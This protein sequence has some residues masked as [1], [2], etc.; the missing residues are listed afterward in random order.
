ML[1][2]QNFL[3]T[4]TL[5]DLSAEFALKIS[6]HPTLPLVILNYNQIESP[7][8]EPLTMECRGL[9]LE[10]G[11][12][13]IVARS[14]C[15]FFNF[16]ETETKFI[17]DQNVTAHEKVDGS[18]ILMYFYG[19]WHI[20]TRGSF[21]DG[22]LAFTGK[23]WKEWVLEAIPNKSEIEKLDPAFT[24]IMEFVSPYNKVVRTYPQPQMYLLS[25]IQ[26]NTGF[27]L[28]IDQSDVI[29]SA[30]GVF[31]PKRFSLKVPEEIKHFLTENS[32]SDPTFEG[33]VLVDSIGNRVKFKAET[34]VNLHHLVDNGNIFNPSRL[35]PLVLNG[36]RDEVVVYL[37]EVA[38][39]FDQVEE[40]LSR[41]FNQMI[42][43]WEKVK[44]IE[45]QKEFAIQLVGSTPFSSILFSARKESVDPKIVWNRS[46][47]LLVKTLFKAKTPACLA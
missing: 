35:V 24:Y 13:N 39:Y 38:P 27:E 5:E 15:R 30:L 14:F 18:L 10:V 31:R 9:V 8:L 40:V 16:G 44:G 19:G 1:N 2:V 41:E 7:K 6:N 26:T 33:F 4:K 42:E 21:A 32:K 25:V 36:E 17:W 37:P 29:A 3:Q 46:P 28:S 47:E 22:E 12:W 43:I 23:S 34:Y 20:N 11:S 45:S